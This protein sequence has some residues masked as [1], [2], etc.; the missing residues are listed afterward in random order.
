MQAPGAVML[1][2]FW[3]GSVLLINVPSC[4]RCWPSAPGASPSSVSRG[5]AFPWP[6]LQQVPC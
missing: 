1:E 6:Q 5:S 3:R 2:F 4:L